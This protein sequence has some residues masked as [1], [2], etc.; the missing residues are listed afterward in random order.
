MHTQYTYMQVHTTQT[1]QINKQT[2]Y[3]GCIKP[4]FNF[5]PYLPGR[6][7][8]QWQKNRQTLNLVKN[9]ITKRIRRKILS[10]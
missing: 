5:A 8:D 7:N 10:N 4:I 9:I 6:P 3:V 1:K 2:K